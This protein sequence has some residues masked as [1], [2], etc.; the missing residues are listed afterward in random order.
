M[1]REGSESKVPLRRK[2]L[3]RLQRRLFTLLVL[4]F[5][6]AKNSTLMAV[7]DIDI[8]ST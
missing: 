6:N 7:S 3:C 4:E 1:E 5:F 2:R 8:L